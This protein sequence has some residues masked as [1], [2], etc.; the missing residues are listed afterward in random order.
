MSGFSSKPQDFGWAGKAFP[1]SQESSSRKSTLYPDPADYLSELPPTVETFKITEMV[2]PPSIVVKNLGRAILMDSEMKSIVMVHSPAH[3]GKGDR[4]PLWLATI[5]S[6]LERVREA[7]ALWRAAVDPLHE[8]LEKS[9]T[10]EAAVENIKASL[11]ALKMLP[12]DG[13]VKGFRAGGSVESLTHWFTKDWLN[14]DHEDHLLELLAAELGISDSSTSCIQTTYFVLA[15]AQAYEKPDRVSKLSAIPMA[16][17]SRD[18]ICDKGSRNGFLTK[19]PA[20][21]RKSLNW[22]LFEHLGVKFKWVDLPVVKQNDP[23]SCGIL[24][25]FALAHWFDAERFQL[26]KCTAASMAERHERKIGSFLS[27]ARDY[28]FTFT[29]LFGLETK[30][31]NLD[32]YEED[33][34]FE[35]DYSPPDDEGGMTS[36]DESSSSR[37]PS[38][39]SPYPMQEFPPSLIPAI[40]DGGR[41]TTPPPS[42]RT[43][44]E[45]ATDT[46]HASPVKKRLKEK[47]KSATSSAMEMLKNGSPSKISALFRTAGWSK[48]RVLTEAEKQDVFA[49]E[50]DE[51]RDKFEDRAKRERRE[52]AAKDKKRK[53]DQNERQRRSRAKKRKAE[54]ALNPGGKKKK[55]QKMMNLEYR[56]TTSQSEVAEASRPAREVA[57]KIKEKTRKPAGRKKKHGD[58]RATYVNWMSPFSWSAIMAAQRKVGSGYT[59][60]VRELQKSN[61]DFF[62][63]LT[64]QTVSGWVEKVG[65]FS[66]WKP[67]V[68]ER[69]NHGNTPGHNK[70]GHEV[71][72]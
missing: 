17:P 68:L 14:T 12:W 5:W 19:A 11:A 22:W 29:H 51:R 4:Y 30:A 20:S 10:S 56:E 38:P 40:A 8:R 34:D 16:S 13:E 50:A 2:V 67:S 46:P 31:E 42:K 71:F 33:S 53:A 1:S 52:K 37:P 15:L 23:H 45:R 66:R 61:Y 6:I 64:P 3:R 18:G 36:T 25:Y 44:S 62:Q 39:P 7:K 59:D 65:G 48:P 58:R 43:H 60:I 49:V 9:T 63:Y 70:G 35:G 54:E 41:P 28:E 21:L 69:A 55:K 47:V 26:P 27:D 24:A 57:G 32:Q 72:W